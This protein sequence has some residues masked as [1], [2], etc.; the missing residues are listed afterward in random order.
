M[1][2]DLGRRTHGIVA[3]R[4]T[5]GAAAASA[6]LVLAAAGTGGAAAQAPSGGEDDVVMGTAGP[7]VLRGGRGDDRLVGRQGSDRLFGGARQDRLEAGRGRDTLRGGPGGDALI[8]GIDDQVDRIIGGRG[9]DIAVAIRN[10]RV[11]L[12]S[13]TDS[14]VVVRPRAGMVIHCGPGNDTA[15]FEEPPPPGLVVEGC[16]DVPVLHDRALAA[17]RPR[18]DTVGA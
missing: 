4:V 8:P 9:H 10:D 1:F 14:V 16:E 7:D 15:T 3:G 13:G 6:V 18:D 11:S 12:G 2:R 5:T 17:L